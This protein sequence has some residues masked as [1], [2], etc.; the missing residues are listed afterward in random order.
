MTGAGV[1][2]SLHVSVGQEQREK[3]WTLCLP[4]FG[5]YISFLGLA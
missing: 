2:L 1:P 3:D 4:R 5:G